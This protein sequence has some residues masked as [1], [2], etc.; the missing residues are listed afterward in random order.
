[1]SAKI[2]TLKDY[3]WITSAVWLYIKY[4]NKISRGNFFRHT[5]EQTFMTNE[6]VYGIINQYFMF[7]DLDRI[8]RDYFMRGIADEKQWPFATTRADVLKF[9][10]DLV[11]TSKTHVLGNERI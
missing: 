1:M 7:G 8:A 10:E 11:A 4:I 2:L 3:D 9:I 6:L 5:Y